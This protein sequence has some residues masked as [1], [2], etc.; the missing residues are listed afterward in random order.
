[1]VS[2]HNGGTVSSLSGSEGGARSPVVA[3]GGD[4]AGA[5]AMPAV[6]V[7]GATGGAGYEGDESGDDECSTAEG[8]RPPPF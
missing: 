4:A 2:Q 7:A 3:T 1:M 8:S 5:I 6:P